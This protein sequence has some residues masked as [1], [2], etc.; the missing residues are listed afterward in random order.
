VSRAVTTID[1]HC[2]AQGTSQKGWYNRDGLW[3]GEIICMQEWILYS[4]FI[5]WLERK[6]LP[7]LTNLFYI[8]IV[9][10]TPS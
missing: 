3:T 6:M 2:K 4:E 8:Q 10:E 9:R 5:N 7:F 1:W